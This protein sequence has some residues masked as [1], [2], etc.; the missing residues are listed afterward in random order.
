[1]NGFK[2]NIPMNAEFSDGGSS[3][4]PYGRSC[5]LRELVV[6][7]REY[8]SEVE[9]IENNTIYIQTPDPSEDYTQEDWEQ[10][11]P[12]IITWVY[13]LPEEMPREFLEKLAYALGYFGRV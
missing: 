12:A 10:N 13:R 9:L 3:M 8:N 4:F 2:R 7:S 6:K 1:M 5:S 11:G